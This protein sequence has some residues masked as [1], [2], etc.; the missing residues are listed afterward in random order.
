VGAMLKS[1]SYLGNQWY[2]NGSLIPGATDSGFTPQVTGNY[3]DIVTLNNCSSAPSN[4]LYFVVTGIN[5]QGNDFIIA[6]PNPA[7][8]I[9][10]ISYKQEGSQPMRIRLISQQGK[11][12][13]DY[14]EEG[15]WGGIIKKY[16]V[17]GVSAGLYFLEISF[18]TGSIIKKL[19]I[20]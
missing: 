14:Q 19:M 3:F 7:S 13:R 4:E 15:S 11:L 17:S 12:I 16:D 2:L 10:M 20:R 8:D 18:R 5:K 1:N 9:V 6:E